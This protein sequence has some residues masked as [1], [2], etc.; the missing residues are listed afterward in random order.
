MRVLRGGSQ[1]GVRRSSRGRWSASK[2]NDT[3]VE[4]LGELLNH[5]PNGLVLF[6]DELSGWLHTMD[7]TTSH[8]QRRK[9]SAGPT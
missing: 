7:R 2:S 3:T 4:K 1:S 5:H 8:F 6:R 9:Q